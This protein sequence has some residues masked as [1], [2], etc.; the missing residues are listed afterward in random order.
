MKF[1]EVMETF[2]MRE[3]EAKKTGAWRRTTK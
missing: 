2:E 1:G 3:R